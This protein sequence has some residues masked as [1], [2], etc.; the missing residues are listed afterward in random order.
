MRAALTSEL[1]KWTTTRLWWVLLVIMAAYMAFLAVVM[2]FSLTLAPTGGTAP[3]GGVD[4]ALTVYTLGNGLGYVFP[5]LAGAM[6]MT[7]EFRYQTITP[8]LLG[9][10]RRGVFLGAKLVSAAVIGLAFGVVGTAASVAGGA[11]ILSLRGDGAFLTEGD[12]LAPIAL[13]VV[14]LA[15]WAFVG[16][17]VGSLITNQV[18]AIV[19]VLAFTQFVEPILRVG[20]SAVDALEGVAKFLPGA[21]SEALVGASTYASLG[22]SELLDRWAGALVFLAY[23]VVLAAIGR[24]TTLRRDIT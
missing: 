19:V 5:L 3:V 2:A 11:P 20:F 10:P 21:A 6:S 23:G 16:V 4:A 8:S 15:I 17:G 13:S 24:W 7:S 1:R 18:A 12:V 9:D 14:A 22:M